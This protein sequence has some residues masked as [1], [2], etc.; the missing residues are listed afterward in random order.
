MAAKNS[1]LVIVESPTKAK[2]VSQFLGKDYTVE[3][4]MGHLRDLPKAK[5]GVDVENNFEPQYVIPTASRKTVTKLKKLHKDHPEVILATDEDREGE[6]IGW[7]I[8]QVL[9]LDP[10]TTPRI[11]FHEITKDAIL[12]SIENP[13]TIN[14]NLVNAQQA[15]R[16]LD[17]LVGYKLSPLLWKKIFRGLSAGRVQSVAVKI[18]VEREREIEKFKP[19]EYW[20]IKVDYKGKEGNILA[21]LVQVDG[22]DTSVNNEGQAKEVVTDLEKN[23]GKVSEIKETKRNRRPMAPFTTSTLQQQAGTLLGFS[24]KKTMLLAQQLYEGVKIGKGGQVGLITYMRTD[25]VSVSTRAVSEMRKFVEDEH[26]AKY[27]PEK[28]NFYKSKNKSSQEA[29]EAVRPT[30]IIRTPGEMNAHLN[31]DQS[32]LYKLIW[33]RTLASQIADAQIAQTDI[34][35]NVVDKYTL[36]SQGIKIEFPGFM[37]V[38]SKKS[39]S[40]SVLPNISEKEELDPKEVNSEQKFTEPPDRYTEPTLVRTLEKLGIGRPSTYAPTIST[41]TTRGY[42]KKEKRH[43]VPQDVGVLV[44]DFLVKH[45]SNI[46]DVDFTANMENELD[47][48]A[49]G[50][51]KWQEII[52]TFY[53]PFEKTLKEKEEKLGKQI[54]DEKTGEKCPKCQKELVIKQGKFGKFMACSGFPDCKHT[55]PIDGNNKPVAPEIVKDEKCPECGKELVKRRS[56]FGEFLGCSGYPECKYIKSTEN[57]KSPIGDIKCPKCDKGKIVERRTKRGRVFYGCSKYPDC[58][59]ASWEQPVKDPCPTCGGLMAINTKKKVPVCQ[60]CGFEDKEIKE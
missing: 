54:E 58:D 8:A 29:H 30:S 37:K 41:L 18:I 13:R 21:D 27:L 35:V 10:A 53:G 22:K 56:R 34:I 6:A 33:E 32:R 2:T 38:M 48:V 40:E 3:A 51:T 7:H 9:D 1:K 23:K 39:I 14:K 19:E 55:Q 43:L 4:S 16:V 25:S 59:F 46:I 28:P 11:I 50:K 42:V 15:R 12:E 57:E 49:E 44:N 60:K 5:L 24:I 17:R 45:F 36:K 47:D 31:S 26:G 52:K 20:K